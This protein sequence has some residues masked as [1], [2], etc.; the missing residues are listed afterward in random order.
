MVPYPATRAEPGV[1][2]VLAVGEA[3]VCLPMERADAEAWLRAVGVVRRI[4]LGR[5]QVE[6]VVWG[7]VV[8]AIRASVND[9]M[10]LTTWRAVA[11]AVGVSEDTIARKRSAAKDESQ[12]W[13]EDAEAARD[14]YAALLQPKESKRARRAQGRVQAGAVDWNAVAR[15]R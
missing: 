10:P 13:F 12:P 11:A 14:W 2:A 9:R 1:A 15:G 8:E 4:G 6:V 5:S 7:D 3:A